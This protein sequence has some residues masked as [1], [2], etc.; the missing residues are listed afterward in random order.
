M[1]LTG[2]AG[3]FRIFDLPAA[4][5]EAHQKVGFFALS[6]GVVVERGN[7]QLNLILDWAEHG[8]LEGILSDEGKWSFA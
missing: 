1:S 6:A 5:V 3:V 4:A 2:K 8:Q 7:S